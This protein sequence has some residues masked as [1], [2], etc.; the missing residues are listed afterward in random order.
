MSIGYKLL[1]SILS[2]LGGILA[3]VLYHCGSQPIN[4]ITESKLGKKVY[5]F[6]NGQYLFDIIYNNYIIGKGAL[7][8][9][10]I[11][12]VLDRGVIETVGPHGLSTVLQNTGYNIAKLETG[13]ITT[14]ALYIT[15]GLLTLLFL[16]FSPILL[17]NTASE[18]IAL[19]VSTDIFRLMIIYISSLFFILW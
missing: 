3:I 1:P 15:L 4:S 10:A 7:A 5:S 6:L 2:I 14:Y 17:N 11:S 18:F 13:V 16:V 19:Y 12:K 8:G 9:Y